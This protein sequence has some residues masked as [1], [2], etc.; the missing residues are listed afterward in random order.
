M[1]LPNGAHESRPWRIH[2]VVPDF[3]LLDVWAL[4]VEGGPHDLE[5]L[6][7]VVAGLDPLHAESL[8]ARTLFRVRHRLGA[9]FGWDDTTGELPIPGATGTTLRDR[10]PADLRDRATGPDLGSSGFVPLYRTETEW[11]AEISNQTVHG[12]LHLAWVEVADGHHRGQ[13]AV[14]VKPRGVVGR[15]YMALIAPFRH[16]VVY[17]A[18][19][20]QIEKAWNARA[21]RDA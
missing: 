12:V 9:L 17:P 7:E 3:R 2:E 14:Y 15:G 5:R 19:T 11:A 6:L 20:R 13:L 10:L 16:L 1:R 4:P 8:A 18:L 21:V